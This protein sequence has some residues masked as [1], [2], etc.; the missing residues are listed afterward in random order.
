[1]LKRIPV[2]QIEQEGVMEGISRK[3]GALRPEGA[4]EAKSL[5]VERALELGKIRQVTMGRSPAL[6][7]PQSRPRMDS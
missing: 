4:G 6:T 7:W 2:R 1:M 3:P 5:A